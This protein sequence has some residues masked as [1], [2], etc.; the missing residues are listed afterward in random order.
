MLS[1]RDYVRYSSGGNNYTRQTTPEAPIIKQIIIINCIMYV[2]CH[3]TGRTGS[4]LLGN[5]ELTPLLVQSGQFWRLGT[6]MFLHAN[7]MHLF[8]NMY[9]LYIFGKLLEQ[10][11]GTKRFLILYLLSGL[12]GGGLWML[13]NWGSPTPCVGASGA[14]FGIMVAAGMAFP[15]VT[16]M[17][18]IP[19]MP[20]KLWVL[21][22]VYCLL[23]I[24]TL[25]QASNVAHLAHL[26]GALGGFIYMRRLG[27]KLT[28]PKL[29]GLR[30]FFR[31]LLPKSSVKSPFTRRSDEPGVVNTAELDRILDK[32]SMVGYNNLSEDE[33]EF[34]RRASA[35]LKNRGR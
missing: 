4:L 31:G 27:C 18:L 35:Q 24:F 16:F 20:V 33:R 13:A 28:L 19:P 3:F 32:V 30:E 12:I 26:G 7:F 5:L 25:G 23:E 2:L 8:F 6:Y 1:D 21:V 17:L 29:A 22:L 11:L 9:G 34:L 15:Q 10:P 14:L